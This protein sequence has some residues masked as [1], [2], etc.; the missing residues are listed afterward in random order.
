MEFDYA[1]Q[2]HAGDPVSVEEVLALATTNVIM[3][4]CALRG[5]AVPDFF[6]L[7]I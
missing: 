1:A 5:M 6:A 2:F 4:E 7:N 3:A